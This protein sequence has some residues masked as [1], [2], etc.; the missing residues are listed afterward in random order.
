[1]KD[2]YHTLGLQ[3]SA[4]AQEIKSAYR[5]LACEYHPDHNGGDKQK[6]AIFKEI[7]EANEVLSDPQKKAEYDR[8]WRLSALNFTRTWNSPSNPRTSSQA[9]RPRAPQAGQ[10]PS[11]PPRQNPSGGSQQ[12]SPRPQSAQTQAPRPVAPASGLDL[13]GAEHLDGFQKRSSSLGSGIKLG[14]GALAVA[15]L[16]TLFWRGVKRAAEWDPD[17]Q[18]YRGEDGRFK[19]A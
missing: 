12:R 15:G 10:P 4:S 7:N 9:E 3:P 6:E 13:L 16:A 14:L 8:Q 1:M 19:R 17:V 11:P 5:K 2:H 18:R